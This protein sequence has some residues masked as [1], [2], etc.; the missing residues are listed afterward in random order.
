[1]IKL[2]SLLLKNPYLLA[3]MQGYSDIAQR[4]ICYSYGCSY[5]FSE[6]I[7]T[8]SF[9]RN[10]INLKLLDFYDNPGIQFLS[11][12]PE[13]L[14]KA[15]LM[16]KERT[17]YPNLENI[18]SID[19]N[20]GCPSQNI[21]SQHMG[22]D[23]LDKPRLVRDMFRIM[24]KHS[25]LPISAKLRLAKNTKH[26][27]SSPYLRIAKI[28]KEEGLDFITI[29]ARTAGQMYEG[30]VDLA[31]L[32]EVH[33]EV[34]IPLIGNGGIDTLQKADS[35]LK[36]CDAIMVGKK[37]NS[38][39]Y[40]FQELLTQKPVHDWR[41]LQKT[42]LKSYLDLAKKY[43]IGFQHIKLHCQALIEPLDKDLSVRLTHTRNI[44]ELN[45]L[46]NQV[47]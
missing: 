29:H 35:M 8:A 19:L 45:N 34:D 22:S 37:A 11:A 27:R 23:L 14:K 24:R 3:P 41:S 40:F 31:A 38:S 47:S 20:V 42:C 32:K 28:A 36:C 4:L 44:D 1:M 46:L 18:K 33:E 43:D 30:P 5:A 16:V 10:R 6:L 17:F 15:I 9:I 21:M 26:K 2:G 39:P 25:H 13:E 7:P 12:K